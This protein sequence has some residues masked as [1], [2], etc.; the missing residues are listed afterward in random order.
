MLYHNRIGNYQPTSEDVGFDPTKLYRMNIGD[1]RNIGVEAL[2]ELDVL[3]LIKGKDFPASLSLFTNAA[4]IDARYFNMRVSAF[5]DR[6]V[7]L[8][9]NVNLKSGLNFR[10]KDL[11]AS[12]MVCYTGKQFTDATNSEFVANAVYGEIP[13]YY[14]MDISVA[15]S[16]KWFKLSSGMNNMTNNQ[17][18]TRRAT[19][20]PG[21][22]IIPA[23]GRSFYVTLQVKL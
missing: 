14:V 5:R 3:H 2:V 6:K 15:Y 4:Y 12:Y 16:W 22:G 9:P 17:Y 11:E 23:E 21:P 7:E 8:V 13:A 19:A 1:S 20:Y 10:W 18:F